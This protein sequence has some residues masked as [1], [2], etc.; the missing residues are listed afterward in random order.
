MASWV[1]V[2]AN[3]LLMPLTFDTHA[4]EALV[5]DLNTK[6]E[7]IS[8]SLRKGAYLR[9]DHDKQAFEHT[10]GDIRERKNF[11]AQKCDFYKTV[12]ANL[13]CHVVTDHRGKQTYSYDLL[14][15]KALYEKLAPTYPYDIRDNW[16]YLD[17]LVLDIL[18]ECK[19]L[20]DDIRYSKAKHL[21][22]DDVFMPFESDKQTLTKCLESHAK[23]LS[24]T[25][26]RRT[27]QFK[28][29]VQK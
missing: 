9:R 5:L 25:K 26:K 21:P 16:R 17:Y 11:I 8:I 12:L 10:V 29:P 24:D 19:K 15:C 20:L 6:L 1:E 14:L 22:A 2:Q 7:P 27:R 13:Q 4:F 3:Y 28:P 18:D 23:K